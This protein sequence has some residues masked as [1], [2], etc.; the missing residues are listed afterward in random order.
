MDLQQPFQTAATLASGEMPKSRAA[1]NYVHQARWIYPMLR[2]GGYPAPEAQGT[3][4]YAGRVPGSLSADA[5]QD[6]LTPILD[7][8]YTGPVRQ[9]VATPWQI[10]SGAG[11]ARNVAAGAGGMLEIQ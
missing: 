1:Y 9:S 6:Y 8:M 10:D 2:Y 7:A 4:E 3:L 11:V 5:P